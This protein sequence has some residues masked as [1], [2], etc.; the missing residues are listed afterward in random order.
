MP[1][2]LRGHYA[3]PQW[4]T[5]WLHCAPL[6]ALIAGLLTPFGL[7]SLDGPIQVLCDKAADR[8]YV[9]MFA[10]GLGLNVVANMSNPPPEGAFLKRS[11][12]GDSFLKASEQVDD[13]SPPL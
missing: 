5:R 13:G 9:T 2:P 3:T 6:V 1:T 11:H 12:A 8:L 4:P 7:G 10:C